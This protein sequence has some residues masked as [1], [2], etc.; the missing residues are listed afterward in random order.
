MG[1][2][3]TGLSRRSFFGA[4]AAGVGAVTGVPTLLSACSSGSG[5]TGHVNSNDLSAILPKFAPAA[6]GPTP[7]VPS[8]SGAAAAS[9]DPGYL[10]YS[11]DL[12][13]TVSAIPGT[14]GS[15]TAITRLWGPIPLVIGHFTKGVLLGAIKG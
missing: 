8:V 13:K 2:A 3:G 14:G 7:D 15:Y 9:T 10:K 5:T 4:A 12:V 1:T 11:T 6:G